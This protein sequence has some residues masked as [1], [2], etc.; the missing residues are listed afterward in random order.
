ML[1][2]KLIIYIYS[3]T[4][5]TLLICVFV[6]VW[7]RVLLGGSKVFPGGCPKQRRRGF[8]PWVR[9]VWEKEMTTHFKVFL[10]G[11]FM[12]EGLAGT[13]CG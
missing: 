12:E 13:V 5:I 4:F 2:S 9:K 11:N 6:C 8:N 3:L 1:P 10:S 7:R